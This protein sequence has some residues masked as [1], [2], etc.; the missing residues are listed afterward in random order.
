MEQPT[1]FINLFVCLITFFISLLIAETSTL[2]S[3]DSLSELI[4]IMSSL[5]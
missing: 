1:F 3:S 5:R 2:A 4:S